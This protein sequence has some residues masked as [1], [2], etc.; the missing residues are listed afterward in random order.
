VRQVLGG[1]FAGIFAAVAQADRSAGKSFIP[2][3]VLSVVNAAVPSL[4]EFLAWYVTPHFRFCFSLTCA[5]LLIDT[6]RKPTDAVT[7]YLFELAAAATYHVHT[8]PI[9]TLCAM[10]REQSSLPPNTKPTTH[11]P[12]TSIFIALPSHRHPPPTHTPSVVAGMRSGE[13]SSLPPITKL[14]THTPSSSHY[15]TQPPT[16]PHTLHG[17][18]YEEWRTELTVIKLTIIRSVVLR[19][20]GLYVFM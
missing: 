19:F 14:A 1:C 20:I 12:C 17:C 7:S 8:H 10:S 16:H 3:I 9:T 13:Q 6:T 15:H 4:F 11:L 18:R 2:A 5:R